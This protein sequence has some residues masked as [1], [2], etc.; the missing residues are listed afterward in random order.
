MVSSHSLTSKICK[1]VYVRDLQN[2]KH[3]E[4]DLSFRWPI[5][6]H[7]DMYKVIRNM[8]LFLMTLSDNTKRL[9]NIIYVFNF[10]IRLFES[11]GI[12]PGGTASFHREEGEAGN[13]QANLN[14]A[15]QYY[16]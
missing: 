14:L 12:F 3:L 2:A 7:K 5:T 1:D 8:L 6:H 16:F 9:T 10:L 15:A 4:A 13:L 11:P